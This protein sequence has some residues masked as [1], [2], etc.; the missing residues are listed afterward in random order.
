MET[1]VFTHLIERDGGAETVELE[2]EAVVIHAFKPKV[3]SYKSISVDGEELSD[4]EIED[5]VEEIGEETLEEATILEFRRQND[6]DHDV[7][8]DDT[9]IRLKEAFGMKT[10]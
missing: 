8:E 1:V 2:I 3:V 10:G 4:S 5:I 9:T 6:T 7:S